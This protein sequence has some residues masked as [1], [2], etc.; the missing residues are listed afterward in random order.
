MKLLSVQ[1]VGSKKTYPINLAADDGGE[2]P[3]AGKPQ[4]RIVEHRSGIDG[5]KSVRPLAEIAEATDGHSATI[6]ALAWPGEIE[7]QVSA[8]A[9]LPILSGSAVPRTKKITS[10]IVV[11][12]PEIPEIA[13]TLTL[14]ITPEGVRDFPA[15]Q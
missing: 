4:W 9:L 2:H 11:V 6:H 5:S 13:E 12:I 15:R 10:T 14:R 3:V 1:H 8:D 7:V